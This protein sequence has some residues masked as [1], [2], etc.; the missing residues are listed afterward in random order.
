M[1]WSI[2]AR[3]AE[4]WARPR[5]R[6]GGFAEAPA[7]LLAPQAPRV[8]GG[9]HS[10]VALLTRLLGLAT[11]NPRPETLA[12]D[13]VARFGSYARVLA[14]TPQELLAVEGLGQHAVA[15]I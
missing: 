2:H 4:F 11:L 15:G 13:V 14:A 10:D 1:A 5:P 7:A 8:S 12:G 9:G 6:A 3:I